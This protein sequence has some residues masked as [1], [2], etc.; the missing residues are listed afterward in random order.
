MTKT[1]LRKNFKS[2]L[3][4]NNEFLTSQLEK[5]IK[6]GALNIDEY[7]N[8]MLLPKI[9]MHVACLNLADQW[10]PP[11]ETGRKEIKNLKCFM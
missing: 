7:E 6:S 5:A 11:Y 9:I 8:N 2:L 1:Q 4:E 10:Y 3:K